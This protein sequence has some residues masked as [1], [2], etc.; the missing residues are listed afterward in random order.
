VKRYHV[1][2]KEIDGAVRRPRCRSARPR[3]IVDL[4]RRGRSALPLE[5]FLDLGPAARAI[6]AHELRDR[7]VALLPAR[8]PAGAGHRAAPDEEVEAPARVGAK[9]AFGPAASARSRRRRPTSGQA[10]LKGPSHR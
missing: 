8:A 2:V 3:R 5:D 6:A 1:E 10:P 7:I 9:R 4:L